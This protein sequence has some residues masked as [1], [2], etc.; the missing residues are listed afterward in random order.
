MKPLAALLGAT[1]IVF[2]AFT[3]Q[4][5]PTSATPAAP[6][7]TVHIHNFAFNPATL[8]VLPGETV[9]WINDDDEPHVVAARD[10]AYRSGMLQTGAT[11]S[12]VYAAAGEFHYYCTMHPQMTGIVVV[13]PQ[14]S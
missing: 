9:T 3:W 8:T 2:A 12:H 11:F 13:R 4:A 14:G 7:V 6:T 10:G 5:A 1:A